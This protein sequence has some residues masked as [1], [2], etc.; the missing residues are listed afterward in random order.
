MRRWDDRG[1]LEN[2]LL[3]KAWVSCGM[4]MRYLKRR[5]T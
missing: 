1:E 2:G 4:L 5:C 3:E